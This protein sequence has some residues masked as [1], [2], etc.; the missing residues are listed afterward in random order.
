[1]KKN[2]KIKNRIEPA[3]PDS[4]SLSQ[5]SQMG[6]PSDSGKN[7]SVWQSFVGASDFAKRHPK[8]MLG[9]KKYAKGK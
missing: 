7:K 8:M 9:K 2:I 6:L 3:R 5:R 1:M 4:A